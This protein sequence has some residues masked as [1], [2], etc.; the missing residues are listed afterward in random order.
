LLNAIQFGLLEF[1][2]LLVP[3]ACDGDKEVH[4]SLT[5]AFSDLS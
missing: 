2:K 4:E 3:G 5:N 1:E